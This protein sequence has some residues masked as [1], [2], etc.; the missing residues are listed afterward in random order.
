MDS[1]LQIAHQVLRTHRR[2]LSAKQILKSAYQLGIVPPHLYGKT[3]HKTLQARIA[4]D[5]LAK[6]VR[7]IFVR[8]EPGRFTLR[9]FFRQP[10]DAQIELH[11]FAAPRRSEQLRNFFVLCTEAP[12][13]DAKSVLDRSR[14]TTEFL[15]NRAL[16]YRRLSEI[17]QSKEMLFARLFV[18]VRK[19][20]SILSRMTN[21]SSPYEPAEEGSVAIGLESYVKE[22]D[23]NLF[24]HDTYGF[25]E[26]TFRTMVEQFHLLPTAFQHD[27]LASIRTLGIVLDD[28]NSTENSFLV[29]TSYT[30][31]IEFDPVRL[32]GPKS[33]LSWRKWVEGTN[34][35]SFFE[36]RSRA[37]IAAGLLKDELLDE[38]THPNIGQGGRT[39]SSTTYK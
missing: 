4:E 38:N 33:G 10:A 23:F 18:I 11:E 6:R 21:R 30:C 14:Q 25:V 5:I 27:S 26:A 1:Y 13:H 8:T 31:P 34:D 15:T 29:V 19:G 7:S 24:S 35:V 9:E 12:S 37:V 3:Q 39:H 20:D 28:A 17:W 2:S 16:Q 22:T 36:P 32:L